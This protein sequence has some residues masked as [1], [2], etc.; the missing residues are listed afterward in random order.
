[1]VGLF[2]GGKREWAVAMG[3]EADLWGTIRLL[4]TAWYLTLKGTAMKTVLATLAAL[5]ALAGLALMSW[6]FIAE[7]SPR[8]IPLIGVGLVL[9]GGYTLWVLIH[10]S[11]EP[12]SPWPL[13]VGQTIALLVGL[14]GLVSATVASLASADPEYGPI[15]LSG[16]IAAQAMAALYLFAFSERRLLH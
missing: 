6:W 4:A 10:T 8:V 2:P 13:L 16:L 15:T 11:N 5:G 3:S 12:A 7:P 9:Q 14:G 1:M